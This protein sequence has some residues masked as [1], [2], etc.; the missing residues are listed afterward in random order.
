MPSV[1]SSKAENFDHSPKVETRCVPIIKSANISTTDILFSQY[2]Y[3][4]Q[5]TKEADTSANKVKSIFI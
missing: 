2:W 3:P 4:V 1:Q 5:V